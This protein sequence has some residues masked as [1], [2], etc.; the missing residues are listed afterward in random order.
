MLNS[1]YSRGKNSPPPP[2]SLHAAPALMYAYVRVWYVIKLEP[3]VPNILLY[4]LG[5]KAS[6]LYIDEGLILVT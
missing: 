6:S 2:Y 5:Q 3:A 4:K 1:K